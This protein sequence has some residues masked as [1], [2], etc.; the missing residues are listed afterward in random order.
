MIKLLKTLLAN[1]IIEY[2]LLSRD[3]EPDTASRKFRCEIEVSDVIGTGLVIGWGPTPEKSLK[4]A[5][6]KFEVA[7]KDLIDSAKRLEEERS[8]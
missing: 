2:V 1:K 8:E 7:C 5:G 4:E 6:K 3:T